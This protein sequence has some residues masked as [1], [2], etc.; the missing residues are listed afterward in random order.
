[1]KNTYLPCLLFLLML[2]CSKNSTTTDVPDPAPNNKSY[3]TGVD[4]STPDR[5]EWE[6][7]G[8]ASNFYVLGYGYDV[9]G[10]Y[11][12]PISVRNSVVDV[13]LLAQE[14]PELV[15]NFKAISGSSDINFNG[16]I[17]SCQE[18]LANLSGIKKGTSIYN[19][20]F[21]TAFKADTSFPS[22]DYH[23]SGISAINTK[24]LIRF[25]DLSNRLNNY[26]TPQFTADVAQLSALEIIAKYGTH[27]LR[28][29]YIGE[30]IDYL[31]RASTHNIQHL[32]ARREFITEQLVYDNDRP[33]ED[34]QYVKENF[35]VDLV[36]NYPHEI[37]HWMIDFTNYTGQAIK[38]G[39]PKDKTEQHLSLVNYG[40]TA[41]IP[42][43]EFVV[44]AKKKATLKEAYIKYLGL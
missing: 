27:V 15:T 10:K 5:I 33:F 6:H 28:E 8:T 32:V 43:Y 1:M 34:N 3:Y 22:L 40:D 36:S 13:D 17:T 4:L 39:N 31:Y 41:L 26:L 20:V 35:A 38:L 11:A 30:R 23:Y 18:S 37:N 12:H 44:D 42:I 14:E 16:S 21:N 2:G 19:G 24:Y 7:H 29:V 25:H 9:T